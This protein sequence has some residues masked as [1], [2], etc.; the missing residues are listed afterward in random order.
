MSPTREVE[1]HYV[2]AEMSNVTASN[3]SADPVNHIVINML[4]ELLLT[5]DVET[6]AHYLLVAI[7]IYLLVFSMAGC[8]SALI[9]EKKNVIDCSRSQK[10]QFNFLVARDPEIQS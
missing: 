5:D 4:D 6:V 3:V 8:L 1:D 10:I 7:V 2:A 9:F